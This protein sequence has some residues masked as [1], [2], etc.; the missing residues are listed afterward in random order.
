M[1]ANFHF[2]LIKINVKVFIIF[3]ISSFGLCS[4]WL[5]RHSARHCPSPE[6]WPRRVGSTGLAAPESGR[7]GRRGCLFVDV[8][9]GQSR[10]VL[11]SASCYWNVWPYLLFCPP[12][13]QWCLA[14]SGCFITCG[15]NVEDSA[16]EPVE[17]ETGGERMLLGCGNGFLKCWNF[18]HGPSAL[19]GCNPQAYPVFVFQN[20]SY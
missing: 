17:V 1:H 18:F 20:Y 9:R 5:Q 14:P 11:F 2:M 6:C 19:V 3:K 16:G 13:L 4:E 8:H 10:S 12:S 15:L 7:L